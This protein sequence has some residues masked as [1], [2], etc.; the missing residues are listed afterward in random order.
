[1]KFLW[2]VFV[3]VSSSVSGDEL[4]PSLDNYA[5]RESGFTAQMLYPAL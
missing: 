2:N 5:P 4:F 3:T 1:M